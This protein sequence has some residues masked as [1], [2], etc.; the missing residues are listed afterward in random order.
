MVE[1]TKNKIKSIGEWLNKISPQTAESLSHYELNPELFEWKSY[2][3]A[4][5]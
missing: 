1:I 3:D 5:R 2:L 4:E